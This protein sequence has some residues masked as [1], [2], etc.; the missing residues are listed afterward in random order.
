MKFQDPNMHGSKVTGGIKNLKN[1]RKKPTHKQ[2]AIC[3]INFEKVGGI[4]TN[5]LFHAYLFL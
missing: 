2:N 4:K 5:M 3:P 1:G